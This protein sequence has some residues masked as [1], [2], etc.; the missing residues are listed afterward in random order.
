MAKPPKSSFSHLGKLL[1]TSRVAAGFSQ[2]DIADKL[3]Y[4]TAQ[5]VSDWERGTRSPP[6][7]IIKKLA[8]LYRIPV[9]DL[10]EVL[11]IERSA[12]LE[13]KL[14]KELGIA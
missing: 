5:V 11:L 6:M 2:K 9:E 12:I 10:F 4:S 14:R 13:L 8:K 7:I 1:Q 3:G